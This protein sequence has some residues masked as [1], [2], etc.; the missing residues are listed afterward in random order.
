[1]VTGGTLPGPKLP[2]R[3]TRVE[4]TADGTIMLTISGEPGATHALEN[5]TVL[6]AWTPLRTLTNTTGTVQYSEKP[7]TNAPA[8]FY[9]ISTPQ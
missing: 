3:F 2:P 5:A 9:R 7:P 8:R 6:G 1:V 4:Q